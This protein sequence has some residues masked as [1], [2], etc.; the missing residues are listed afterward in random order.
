[1][2]Q[3]PVQVSLCVALTLALTLAGCELLVHGKQAQVSIDPTIPRTHTEIVG[4]DHGPPRPVAAMIWP[5]TV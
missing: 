1:M 5:G 2:P 3:I 4:L